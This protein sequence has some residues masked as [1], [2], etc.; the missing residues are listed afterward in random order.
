MT[1]FPRACTPDLK[2][3]PQF[4]NAIQVITCPPT[5]TAA[6]LPQPWCTDPKKPF[7]GQAAALVAAQGSWDGE[8]LRAKKASAATTSQCLQFRASVEAFLLPSSHPAPT[9]A[10]AAPFPSHSCQAVAATAVSASS[11]CPCLGCCCYC[12]LFLDSLQRQCCHC[13]RTQPDPME[14]RVFAHTLPVLGVGCPH[15][16]HP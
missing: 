4:D 5:G 8:L 13:I 16:S 11:S 15:Q 12:C 3:M 2:K 1:T 7:T 14:T 9:A 10:P 6:G